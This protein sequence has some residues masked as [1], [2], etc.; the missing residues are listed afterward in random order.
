[1][2]RTLNRREFIR[3][4]LTLSA[5]G[6]ALELSDCAPRPAATPTPAATQARPLATGTPAAGQALARVPDT[7]E[8]GRAHV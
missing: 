3:H 4:I 2:S 6:A 8:I 7:P 5:T 1:M